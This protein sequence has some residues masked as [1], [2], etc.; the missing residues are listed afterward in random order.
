MCTN[1]NKGNCPT[2]QACEL[3]IQFAGQ[4][5]EADDEPMPTSFAIALWI[6]G[7]RSLPSLSFRS[8]PAVWPAPTEEVIMSTEITET[9]PE[10]TNTLPAAPE[11]RAALALNATKTAADLRALVEKHQPL[12]GIEVKD[13]ATRDQLH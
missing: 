5:P 9:A 11:A 6:A 10:Q 7:S 1:C 2:P 13:K 8:S 4:E 12:K 3:P